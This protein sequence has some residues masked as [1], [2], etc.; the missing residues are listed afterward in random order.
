MMVEAGLTPA[1]A[2]R[3][4]T[5]DAAKCLQIDRELGTL[6]TGKWADFVVL[7]ASPLERMQHIRQQHSVWI[8]GQ[9]VGAPR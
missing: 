4:A 2:L 3:S 5:L 1:Q 7:N 6:E 9:R 8:G